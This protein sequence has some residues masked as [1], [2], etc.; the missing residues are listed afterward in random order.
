MG[1]AFYYA[2]F[3]DVQWRA[4]LGISLVFPVMMLVIIYLPFVPESPRF[5]LMRGRIDEAREVTMRLHHVKDDPDQ[6]FARSEFYQMSKQAE[7]DRTLNPSWVCCI[8]YSRVR[9]E[10]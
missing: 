6:E 3:G 8:N 2:P 4:P 10:N 5:L 7:F 1:M 9:V